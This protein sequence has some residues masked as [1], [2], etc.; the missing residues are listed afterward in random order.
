MG[1]KHAVAAKSNFD[2][3]ARE[4]VRGEGA[5]LYLAPVLPLGA[6][7]REQVVQSQIRWVRL[8]SFDERFDLPGRCRPGRKE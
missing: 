3:A 6:G 1:E 2:P 7:D 5:G 4:P 8:T